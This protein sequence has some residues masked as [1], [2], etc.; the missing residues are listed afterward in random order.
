VPDFGNSALEPV[1]REL[2]R[3]VRLASSFNARVMSTIRALAQRDM[4]LASARLAPPTRRVWAAFAAVAAGLLAVA[5]LPAAPSA[6]PQRVQFVLVA[7]D[8][9]TVN[10]VGDFNGWNRNH[11]LFLAKNH[12]GGVWSVT[13]PVAP[14]YHRY[15]F[16]VD[17]SLWVTDPSASR[18]GDDDSGTPKSAIVVEQQR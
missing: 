11:P 8:A 6:R 18:V 4:R 3:P 13:A 1:I 16:L 14:G 2:R 5:V 9:K 15:A 7:P 17:D 10:V 12:G